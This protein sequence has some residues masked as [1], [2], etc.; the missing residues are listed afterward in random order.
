MFGLHGFDA[1]NVVCLVLIVPTIYRGAAKNAIALRVQS[2]SQVQ[3]PR[4]EIESPRSL[5]RRLSQRAHPRSSQLKRRQKWP[6]PCTARVWT[7]KGQISHRLSLP[8]IPMRLASSNH[9][10]KGL[11]LRRNPCMA[12]LQLWQ[13]AQLG[14]RHGLRC[15]NAIKK[16]HPP[17]PDLARSAFLLTVPLLEE[18][19]GRHT[20]S[21]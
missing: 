18:E 13:C 20:T 7:A 15:A 9:D 21:R 6:E 19:P 16:V 8:K 11:D 2:L 10:S 4:I 14:L 5:L 3:K 1:A 12:V 17:L